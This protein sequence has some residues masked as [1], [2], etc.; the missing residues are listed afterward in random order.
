ML[1]R[2]FVLLTTFIIGGLLTSS[3]QQAATVAAKPVQ[4]SAADP[5]FGAV[6]SFWAANEAVELGVGWERILFY[7]NEIQPTGPGDWNTLHVKEEWLNEAAAQGRQVVGL[8][9]NTPVWATEG[10]FAAG[11]PRG[12][13]LPVD[14]P[15]NLWANYVRQVSGYYGQRGVHHWI[16]WNEPDIAPNVYG[17]EFSGSID[18]Y[19]QLLKVAYTVIKQ[20]NPNAIV[21]LGGMTYWHDP[22]YL[23][24]FLQVVVNDPDAAANNYYFDVIS[25]HIYF[26]PETIA[27]IVGNAF[28]VQQQMGIPLKAVWINE[29]NAR[30]SMDPEWPVQVESFP[31]DLDQQAWFIPQA[32]AIGFYSGAGRIAVYKLVDVNLAPGGES[33][34]LVRPHDFSRRPAY[35]AYQ[36]TIK[37]LSGFTYPI[38]REQ[39][40]NH[41]LFSFSRP[42]GTTRVMWARN[43]S[44]VTLQVP[45]LAASALL[46]Q[47]TGETTTIVPE[48][49]SYTVTLEA[50]RCHGECYMGG[51]P[52][53]LVED[54]GTPGEAVP[55]SPPPPPPTNTPEVIAPTETA[56]SAALSTAVF[57]PTPI[58]T[59]TNTLVPPTATA[60]IV[61]TD[62]PEPTATATTPATETA[63]P[64]TS[65]ST[66]RPTDTPA[67]TAT[68]TET[69][70]LP[71]NTAVSTEV[72]MGVPT[73]VP[74]L[75]M[76]QPVDE[77]ISMDWQGSWWLIGTA[78]ILSAALFLFWK[79][80]IQ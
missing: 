16:I 24:K 31:V 34:G 59:A 57:T 51:P 29:T 18:D 9:K 78:V 5:R 11:V 4:Q 62:T 50:A 45:A 79:K 20:A 71:T 13:Y 15:G 14:D 72:A 65:T 22:G 56:T 66:P 28:A 21:H 17:H 36:T 47:A 54:G 10:E 25:L 39:S 43:Q 64:P 3:L 46:V 63:V 76:P 73:A 53:F 33:W 8:L 41:Y 12:L 77:G 68:M 67:P 48:N 2:L 7:W 38:Q 1:K 37:Y 23:R 55:T 19:Y 26:R 6:E 58:I 35:F 32:F 27:T 80:S 70:V 52:V 60:T 42:Q 69:A 30:P 61:P 75:A 74:T 40:Y 49:G 44:P